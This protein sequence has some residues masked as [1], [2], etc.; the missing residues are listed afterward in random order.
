MHAA[1]A[2]DMEYLFKNRGMNDLKWKIKLSVLKNLYK[3]T[4]TIEFYYIWYDNRLFLNRRTL[5]HKHYIQKVRYHLAIVSIV[6]LRK[7]IKGR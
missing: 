2:L 6:Y 1:V 3:Y 4:V 7:V 5:F